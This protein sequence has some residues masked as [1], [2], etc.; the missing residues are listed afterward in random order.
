MALSLLQPFAQK[1]GWKV[2][3]WTFLGWLAGSLVTWAAALP[4]EEPW[5]GIVNGFA[6]FL[7]G[8][9]RLLIAWR[10]EP[11][12]DATT[13]PK[14]TAEEFLPPA[15]LVKVDQAVARKVDAAQRRAAG[16]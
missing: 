15:D 3:L 2:L 9:I 12:I 1:S 7:S 16:Y 13:I 4:L 8:A 6:G 10:R 11:T 14:E 5:K